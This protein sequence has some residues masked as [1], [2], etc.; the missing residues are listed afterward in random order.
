MV[1]LDN[2][3]LTCDCQPFHDIVQFT[4][5]ARPVVA[6]EH[7]KRCWCDRFDT[8]PAFLSGALEKD[9]QNWFN[10]VR[11]FT[12]R[13]DAQLIDVEPIVEIEPEA[14]GLDMGKQVLICSGDDADV[15]LVAAC[16]AERIDHVIFQYS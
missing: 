3:L 9:P 6:L 14:A 15:D 16:I 5:I 11:P 2:V 1:R 8:A 12:Q 7:G 10:V 13:R 4:D